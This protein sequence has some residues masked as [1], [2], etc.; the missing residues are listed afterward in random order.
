MGNFFED[1]CHDAFGCMVEA[2]GEDFDVT[3]APTV[4]FAQFPHTSLSH[5]LDGI[6]V[7]IVFVFLPQTF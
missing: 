6:Y 4:S 1:H 7:S 5:L 3:D 2:I